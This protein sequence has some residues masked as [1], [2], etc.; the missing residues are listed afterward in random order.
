MRLFLFFITILSLP[1]CLIRIN[2]NGYRDL[3]KD[4]VRSLKPFLL[5]ETDA[6]RNQATELSLVEITGPDIIKCFQKYPYTVVYLWRP[7]CKA[8]SCKPLFYYELIDRKFR[9]KGV[10][11]LMVSE[12]YQ[13]E[14]I[15]RNAEKSTYDRDLYVMKDAEY[16]HKPKAGQKKIEREIAPSYTKDGPI[17]VAEQYFIFKKNDLVYHGYEISDHIV[18]SV[19]KNN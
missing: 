17:D 3:H 7:Y 9:D 19:L 4:Q 11:L 6:L 15:K 14:L 16:G 2:D 8:T 1:S 5:D 13:Y 12:T 18:D 10:K